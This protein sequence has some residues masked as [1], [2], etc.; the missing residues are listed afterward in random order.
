[1]ALERTRAFYWDSSALLIALLPDARRAEAVA[2]SRLPGTH[3]ISTLTWA[4]VL[5][6]I[7][8]Y[9]RERKVPPSVADGARE[10]IGQEPWRRLSDPPD[11]LILR[12]LASKWI[13]TGSDLWHLAL[14]KTLQQD[15]P[16]LGLLSFDARL[17][18]AAAGEGLAAPVT[19]T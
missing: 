15:Q 17:S 8:R 12:D 6:V 2:W 13:L 11:W 19:P 18:K 3:L 1:M 16:E 5:S 9:Q 10:E 7:S 4:E 14:A